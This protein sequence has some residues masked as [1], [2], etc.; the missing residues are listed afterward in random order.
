KRAVRFRWRCASIEAFLSLP[1]DSVDDERHEY[2]R[3]IAIVIKHRVHPGCPG[4][5]GE[6]ALWLTRS[7]CGSPADLLRGGLVPRPFRQ[8]I[9]DV[10]DALS[11]EDVAGRPERFGD[12]ARRVEFV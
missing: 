11:I 1:L 4:A 7:R 8:A 9:I 2:R 3:L 5:S 12:L 10:D 6:S